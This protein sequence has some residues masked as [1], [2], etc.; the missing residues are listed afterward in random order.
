MSVSFSEQDLARRRPVWNALA[1]LFLDT[2]HSLFYQTTATALR[3]SRFNA[4]EAETILTDEVGPVLYTN[5]LSVAGDWALFPSD[6]L[7]REILTHLAKAAPARLAAI[8]A[9]KIVV[10]DVLRIDWPPIRDAVW[11][12][13]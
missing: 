4:A 3:A 7:E 1:D 8:L 9:S 11:G 13:K 6:W 2:D 5:L 12:V 10:S